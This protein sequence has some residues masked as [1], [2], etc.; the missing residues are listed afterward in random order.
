MHPSGTHMHWSH[1][2]TGDSL[3]SRYDGRRHEAIQH[4]NWSSSA[5]LSLPPQPHA[6]ACYVS[7]HVNLGLLPLASRT[8]RRESCALKIS[9]IG[10]KIPFHHHGYICTSIRIAT[11]T[12]TYAPGYGWS[13]VRGAVQKEGGEDNRGAGIA[14]LEDRHRSNTGSKSRKISP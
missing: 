8:A 11:C 1:M 5:P 14:L 12:Y 3:F 6:Y 9:F 4:H 7:T 13:W 2:P 10:G